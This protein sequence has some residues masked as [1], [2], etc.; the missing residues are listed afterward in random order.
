[1]FPKIIRELQK[2]SGYPDAAYGSLL[3]AI[4]LAQKPARALEIGTL[5]GYSACCIA[6]AMKDAEWGHLT[7]IDTEG[8]KV[9]VDTARANIKKAGLENYVRVR[10]VNSN[11]FFARN[12]DYFDFIHVDG[13]HSREQCLADMRNAW[14]WMSDDAVLMLHDTLYLDSVKQAVTEFITE[15]HIAEKIFLK[16][17]NGTCILRKTEAFH[18]RE[19]WDFASVQLHDLGELK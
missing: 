15:N 18:Y 5:A 10:K 7:A 3:Y 19:Y 11:S 2:P 14:Q 4:I 9:K 16:C 8:Y 6:L 1:M 12:H 17:Y 13:D